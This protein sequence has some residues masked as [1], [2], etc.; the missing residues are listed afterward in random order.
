M[1][2]RDVVVTGI[3]LVTP[4]GIG[5]DATWNGLMAGIPTA[6]RDPEL[7][8]LP[9]DFS[10]QV[11]DFDAARLLD[12]MLAAR[13]ERFA[14]MAVVAAREAVASAGLDPA[15]WQGDRVGVV[16]GTA[17]ASFSPVQD[18]CAKMDRGQHHLVS[19]RF[20]PR[21]I[22]N[23]SAAEIGLDLGAR[24]PNLVTSTACASGA[25]AIG[26]ALAML[27]AGMCDV[28]IAGGAESMRSPIPCA[29]FGQMRALSRRGHD[30]AG[31]SRPFDADRDGFV[32]AEG[33]GMLV[34]ERADHARARGASVHAVLAGYGASCDAHHTTAPHPEGEGAA[35]ALR[36]A[37]AD[38]GLAASDIGHVNAHGTGTRL[39]DAA[40]FRALKAVFARPPVVTA[41]KGV[42]GHTIGAAGAVEAAASVL[43][44]RHQV[45]PPTANIERQDPDIDLD[46]VVKAP[47]KVRMGAVATTSFGF[48]GQNAVL[49]F[50]TP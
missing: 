23:M 10:C 24:G 1:K 17:T 7:A 6:R 34:L 12:G 42:L 47:R 11:P 40:E 26:T 20:L 3:G 48:G 49:V 14:A 21:M 45:V 16:A 28:I 5:A 29:A 41:N 43:S 39:N 31:A 4:A 50:T 37:I 25:T 13:L 33:A 35:Q 22:P 15:T 30:P 36:A 8:G 18:V 2:V 46:I 27:R 9:T 19:P 32:L 38:A 44:L